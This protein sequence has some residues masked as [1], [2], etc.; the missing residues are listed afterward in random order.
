MT[1]MAKIFLCLV[2]FICL[3]RRD[4]CGQVIGD[5]KLTIRQDN[6]GTP[7]SWSVTLENQCNCVISD[8]KLACKG[9]QSYS[10]INPSILYYDGDFC[11]I[12]NLLPIYPR[13][14]IQFLYA[15]P[16]G[17]YPFQLVAQLESCS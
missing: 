6:M 11:I 8:V 9:F 15:W 3:I 4:A 1:P 17:Q 13:D 2:L 10:K 7:Q 16:A 14:R 5:C 12:N